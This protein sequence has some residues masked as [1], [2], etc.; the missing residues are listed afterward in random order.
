MCTCP[1]LPLMK[2]HEAMYI[3]CSSAYLEDLIEK[4]IGRSIF[5]LDHNKFFHPEVPFFQKCR[6]T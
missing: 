5:K 4:T 1:V 3:T 6:L 2:Q